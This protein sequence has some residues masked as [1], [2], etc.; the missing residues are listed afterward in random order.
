MK[1]KVKTSS[2]IPASIYHHELPCIFDEWADIDIAL[3]DVR[4]VIIKIVRLMSSTTLKIK[5]GNGK[6]RIEIGGG[7]L[8]TGGHNLWDYDG[9]SYTFDGI[10]DSFIKMKILDIDG[11]EII[12]FKR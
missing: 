2:N 6:S 11:N 4:E 1:V 7:L 3:D 9:I 12:R 8:L 10:V 5:F